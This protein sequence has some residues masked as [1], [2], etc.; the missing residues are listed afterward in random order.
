MTSPE[1]NQDLTTLHSNTNQTG[2]TKKNPNTS[3]P[4]SWWVDSLGRLCMLTFPLISYGSSSIHSSSFSSPP[5]PPSAF[6][7]ISSLSHLL[8]HREDQKKSLTFF[9]RICPSGY[10]RSSPPSFL[11]ITRHLKVS[12]HLLSFSN[13]FQFFCFHSESTAVLLS[14]FISDLLCVLFLLSFLSGICYC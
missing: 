9:C 1:S 5:L 2:N 14:G 12:T 4:C 10:R 11:F 7:H 8:H 3:Q 13:S 6:Y